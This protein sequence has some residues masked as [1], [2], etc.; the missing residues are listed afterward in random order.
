M[1]REELEALGLEKEK[2]DAIMAINGADIE[3][4][5][6]KVES[7]EKDRDNAN[8]TLKETQETLKSFDGVDVKEL[9]EKIKELDGK[10][11]TDG[12]AHAK[13][14]AEIT[15]KHAAEKYLG[16]HKFSSEFARKQAER[17][18]LEA[19]LTYDDKSS[20][21]VGADAF[22][23]KMKEF[24]PTAFAADNKETPPEYTV[25]PTGGKLDTKAMN[26]NFT[27][28]REKPKE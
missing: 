3:T 24:D 11:A 27:G 1:K 13:E 9:N 14:M 10:I 7:A 4:Y 25:P 26:F 17:E 5:K 12:E 28:V 21:F 2:I 15:T 6:K 8:T 20:T 18:F 23:E 22:M 19:G 16:G